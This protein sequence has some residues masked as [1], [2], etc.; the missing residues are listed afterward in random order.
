[1]SVLKGREAIVRFRGKATEHGLTQVW[2]AEVMIGEDSRAEFAN[3]EVEFLPG[4]LRLTFVHKGQTRT[5]NF[6]SEVIASVQ[7]APAPETECVA[8]GHV[9]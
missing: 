7:T 3:A 4:W 6:S 2:D 1:M 8:M 5:I 9:Q